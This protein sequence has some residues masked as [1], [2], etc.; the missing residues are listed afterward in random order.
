MP[1]IKQAG[2]ESVAIARQRSVAAVPDRPDIAIVSLATT[3]GLRRADAA[4]A[5]QIE[6]AGA[7]CEM[8]EVRI[9][10]SG[11]LRRTMALTDV[12]EAWAGRTAARRADAASAVILSGVTTALLAAVDAP[13]VAVRFDGIAAINR[14]GPGGSWQRR[15]ERSVLA[16]ADLLLPWSEA[17]A[18][19]VEG[20]ATDVVVLP[21]PVAAGPARSSGGPDAVAYAGNPHKRGLEL[22]CAAWERV[23][24]RL[25]I[26][27]ID[28]DEGRR[29]LRKLGGGDVP[30]GVE[31]AGD[32]EHERWLETVASA[33]VFL[34]AARIEDW[35]LAQMEALSAG[36]PLVAAPAP[37]AN[38]ALP[39]ARELAPELVAAE[40]AVEPL[41]AALRAGL[42]LDDAARERYAA[43]AARLL[44]PYREPALERRVAEE[45]LPKL[46]G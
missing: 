36:T 28:A 13:R 4:L 21:P 31:F 16:R 7:S 18:A 25:V 42:A 17:A 12:V 9:G 38:A 15:R 33:R 23:E 43:A 41:V 29:R 1:V 30:A 26:G 8:I 24:G 32:L 35:G 2:R 39:L 27:G 10:R 5:R 14:P 46:L 22:L 45:V 3:F 44:E 11:G 37:G 20:V 40:R 34:S 6:A 19:A